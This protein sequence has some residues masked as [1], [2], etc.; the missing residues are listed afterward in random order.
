MPRTQ[1]MPPLH[2]TA[3]P[4]VVAACVGL[5]LGIAAWSLSGCAS[6]LAVQAERDLKRSVLDSVR[7]ETRE[8]QQL[9]TRQT[10]T[11][12]NGLERLQI[13][14]RLLP[15]LQ[16]MAGPE[17]Y[18]QRTDQAATSALLGPSLLG[19]PQEI[20]ELSLQ[21]AVRYAVENNLSLQFARLQPAIAESQVVAAQAAF[22][23][24]LFGTSEFNN[25]DQPR[26]RSTQG[27]VPSGA[28]LDQ[29][30]S[31]TTQLGLR[32]PISSGGTVTLSQDLNRSDINTPGFGQQ[33]NPAYEAAWTLR[34]DQPLLRNFGSD[35]N[36]AQVRLARNA[37]RDSISTL[38]RDLIRTVTQTEAA[39]WRLVQAQLDL[40]ILQRLYERGIIIRDQVEARGILDATPAQRADARA[41]VERRR[42]DVIRAKNSLRQASDELKVLINAP[43]LPVG[44]ETLVLPTDRA[45]DAAVEFSL[46][47][48]LTTAVRARPEL[49]QAILSIDNT[50]IRQLVADNA[51]LPRLDLRLQTRLSGLDRTG[52]DALSNAAER[53][54]IDYLVG[55]Q[56]EQPLGNRAAE[57]QFR[58]RRQER[59]QATIAYR[60]AVQQVVLECKRSLRGL[61]TA[62][63]LIEQTRIARIAETE[64]LRSLQVESKLLRGLDINAL[65]LEFRRQESLAQAERDEVQALVQYQNSLAELYQ[66][67]GT[68]LERNNIDLRIPGAEDALAE[69]GLAQPRNPVS[70]V[71]PKDTTIQQVPPRPAPPWAPR[72]R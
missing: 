4:A 1:T 16:R 14:P 69:G 26:I 23:S 31:I 37:E 64:N 72:N 7:R 29:R 60:N 38:K 27:N 54:F 42:A 59:K 6:P 52:P 33:P 57:A 49:Q 55:L 62:Y 21:A 50:S 25:V 68:A 30:Q 71:I 9:S 65:D 13:E 58:Q 40:E 10:T 61:T 56:F 35:V 36:M 45:V 70:P 32:R 63:D 11:R 28:A 67:M 51:R 44:S 39:Y 48:V 17:S 47:D 15:E 5:A 20:S 46:I 34:F 12:E 22:D 24:V 2:T 8:A 53:D 19:Q 66:A 18:A 43:D 41:R 3:H